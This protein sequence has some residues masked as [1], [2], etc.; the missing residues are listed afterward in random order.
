MSLS[1]HVDA[2]SNGIDTLVVEQ[3]V[4]KEVAHL[5]VPFAI[6][7]E[8]VI[9]CAGDNHDAL[10]V[11]QDHKREHKLHELNHAALG[12]KVL[13]VNLAEV[14]APLVLHGEAE[15][16]GRIHVWCI[17]EAE[18]AYGLLLFG[19]LFFISWDNLL[20]MFRESLG[21]VSEFV[22]TPVVESC[23]SV[24]LEGLI[25]GEWDLIVFHRTISLQV[26]VFYF[27]V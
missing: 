14:V 5:Q 11:I 7:F 6:I 13:D 2:I 4:A 23:V 22:S 10:A 24:F 26:Y 1:H 27:I 8:H 16:C 15:E 19:F 18:L 20:F 12:E 21:S 3:H 17:L 25:F 9:F